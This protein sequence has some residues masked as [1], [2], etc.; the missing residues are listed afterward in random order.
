M[1]NKIDNKN[2]NKKNKNRGGFTLSESIIAITLI[3]IGI[4]GT[5]TLINRAAGFATLTS[6]R[7]TASALGQEG[8]EIVRNIRDSNWLNQRTWTEGLLGQCDG[9]FEVSPLDGL[10]CNSG[11]NLLFD[12][13]LG[14]NY[15]DGQETIFKRVVSISSI[16]SAE[17]KIQA[18]VSWN[19]RGGD[20]D[21]VVEDH[22]FNWY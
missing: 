1:K 9:N 20:F 18:I 2:L 12:D 21:I 16:N 7:L 13:E 8:I 4:M 17:I 5:L 3:L 19:F 15:T 14:Y 10:G 11:R 22:L 6:S